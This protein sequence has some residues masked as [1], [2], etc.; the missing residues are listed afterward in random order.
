MA[1]LNGSEDLYRAVFPDDVHL[2][3]SKN[4]DGAFRG[5]V[6]DNMT[7][8]L[9]GQAEFVKVDDNDGDSG[10]DGLRV[11]LAA[12]AG[13]VGT[14]VVVRIAPTVKR[15]WMRDRPTLTAARARRTEAAADG[16]AVMLT[17]VAP[18]ECELSGTPLDEAEAG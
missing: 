5:A 13:I 9:R 17:L 11:L 4:T 14:L 7:N 12:A 3:S 1:A 18:P 15:W 10:Q 16:K 2:A 8:V 6:L